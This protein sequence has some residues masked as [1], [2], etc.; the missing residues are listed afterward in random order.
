MPRRTLSPRMSTTVTSTS[1]PIM[2][3][4]SRCLD[5]TNI[6]GPFLGESWRPR[7]PPL[8]VTGAKSRG[9]RGRREPLPREP[10]VDVDLSPVDLDV[11]A[12]AE[13]HHHVPVKAAL[14]AVAGLGIA[15]AQR[16]VH[17]AADLFV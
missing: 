15:G 14:V 11:A 9:L 17:G 1:S 7:P 10:A 6:M 8:H 13:V 5:S 4:S 2:T 3:V 12:A 16:E